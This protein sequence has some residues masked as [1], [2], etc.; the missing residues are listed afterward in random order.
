MPHELIQANVYRARQYAL[1]R[2]TYWAVKLRMDRINSVK[3]LTH[4]PE[5]ETFIG[6]WSGPVKSQV[7]IKSDIGRGFPNP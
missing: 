5:S 7:T 2:L 3:L 6:V 4:V 1:G